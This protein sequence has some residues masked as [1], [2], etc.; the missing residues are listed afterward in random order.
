[1]LKNYS[2]YIKENAQIKKFDIGDTVYYFSPMSLFKDYIG[3]CKIL[4]ILKSHSGYWYQ[5]HN[6]NGK[7][8]KW[9]HQS[10][11]F[12]EEKYL[13]FIK[14]EE[15]KKAKRLKNIE[16]MKDIDPY[17]EEDWEVNENNQENQIKYQIGDTFRCV[18]EM[19]FF[20]VGQI[21]KIIE[22]W[23]TNQY[24]VYEMFN[25]TT[26]QGPVPLIEECFRQFEK[27]KLKRIFN[28]ED[29]FGEENWETNERRIPYKKTLCQDLWENGAINERIKNKLVKIA[30]DFYNDI[31]LETEIKD[32][33]LTGSMANYSYNDESDIDVHIVI[34]FSDVNEDTELVKKA[35]DGERFIWNLRHNITIKG[36]DVELYVQDDKEEHRSSGLYSLLND[37]WVIKPVYNPPKVDTEDVN[38]KYDARVY[39]INKFEKLSKTNLTPEEAEEYYNGARELKIK[40]MKSRKE[41]LSEEGEFS[42]ENLVFKKLRKENK[43]KKLIDTITRFYDKIYSQ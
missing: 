43:I 11:L 41:G 13:K 5:L 28:D 3:K 18:K 12:D 9:I 21:G 42:I 29:P 31:E 4:D 26:N 35:I 8:I 38:V 30:K 16:S 19:I 40:I 1:M 20:Q 15:E 22:I 25:L 39:D 37:K 24:I 32:I 7:E 36:H 17:G 33:H 14:K 23:K 34:N 10:E 6:E 2:N 27:I